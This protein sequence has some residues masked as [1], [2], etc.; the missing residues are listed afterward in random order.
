MVRPPASRTRPPRVPADARRAI[1]RYHILE[2]GEEL[3]LKVIAPGH[4]RRIE[5]GIL[6]YLGDINI[7]NNPYECGLGWQVDLDKDNFIGKDALAQ[8]KKEGVKQKLVGLT[9]D[10]GK[11]IDWYI[12]DFYHVRNDADELVGHCTSGWCA[13]L[14]HACARARGPPRGDRPCRRAP[15]YSPELKSNIAMA[16]VP[17]EYATLDTKLHVVLPDVYKDDALGNKVPATV[18][19][20]PF[21]MP[22]A[23]EMGSG[24]RRTGSKL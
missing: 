14:R 9:I 3:G 13:S 5:A 10:G 1:A 12:S 7:E 16:M 24:L 20:T 11:P 22:D 18:V 8:I 4:H 23:A 6:S 15:R 21:K 17:T 19:N 2:Q